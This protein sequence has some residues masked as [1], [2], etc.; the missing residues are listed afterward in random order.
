MFLQKRIANC[1]IQ[2]GAL[3]RGLNCKFLGTYLKIY[4]DLE[5]HCHIGASQKSMEI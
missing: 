4:H 1:N 5:I 3:E 2:Y